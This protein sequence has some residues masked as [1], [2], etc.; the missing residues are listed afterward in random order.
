MTIEQEAT[1]GTATG[2]S[3]AVL[4]DRTVDGGFPETKEL[5]RRVRDI[6]APGRDLGHVDRAAAKETPASTPAPAPAPES[7]PLA[8]EKNEKPT[9][10]CEDCH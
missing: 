10:I 7:A 6:I 3:P 4:W 9:Q 2:S 8:A 1:S 5:K